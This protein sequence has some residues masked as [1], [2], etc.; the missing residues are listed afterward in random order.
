MDIHGSNVALVEEVAEETV[1]HKSAEE[2]A[3]YSMD[4]GVS[5]AEMDKVEEVEEVE[6]AQ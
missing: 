4:D 5:N 2:H 1:E 3:E 6:E